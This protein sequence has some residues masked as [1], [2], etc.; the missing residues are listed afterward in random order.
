MKP[1]KNHE[2]VPDEFHYISGE[3]MMRVLRLCGM[4]IIDFANFIE[5]SENY[6]RYTLAYKKSPIEFKIVRALIHY[7]T[8][9]DYL[10]TMQIIRRKQP[11]QSGGI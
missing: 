9:T 7:V 3:E 1:K 6:V 8:P 5:R 2:E 4:S 10:R 11:V